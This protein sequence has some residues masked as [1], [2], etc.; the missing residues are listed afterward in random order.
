MR[1]IIAAGGTGGHLYPGIAIA[2]EIR[3]RLKEIKV[4][5]VVTKKPGEVETVTGEGFDARAIPSK[6][7]LG[8]SKHERMLLPFYLVAGGVLFFVILLK[9]H[10]RAVVGTGGYASFIPLLLGILWGIPTII[11][12]QDSHPGL[13]TRMLSRFVTEVHL[14]HEA[15]KET[16][17]AR[18]LFVTGNPVRDSILEGTR[19]QAFEHF[20]LERDKKT[21]FIVGGSHGARSINRA[22]SLVMKRQSFPGVQFIFATGR[23]DYRW[24]EEALRESRCS[25]RVLPYIERMNLAYAASDLMF[26]RAGALTLAELMVRG[27]PS[28]LIPF[29]HATGGHQEENA[30]HLEKLGAAVVLLDHELEPE[31]ITMLIE[32]LLHDEERLLGMRKKAKMLGRPDAGER[33]ARRVIALVQG[34]NL[35]S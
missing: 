31:K 34:G 3:K 7:F 18:R 5:F 33:L 4:L 19:E 25:V 17:S 13:T 35:V 1:I 22:F 15:A 11:S 23:S 12:E 8:K 16:L 9:Q 6:G 27:V 29:P 28:V 32:E 14:A 24:V 20:K 30:R 10:P 2:R 26:S 21:V